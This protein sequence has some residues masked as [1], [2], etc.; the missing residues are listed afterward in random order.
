MADGARKRWTLAFFLSCLATVAL[1][2]DELETLDADFLS[3]L[4]EFEGEHDDWT[5]VEPPRKLQ[6]A[7]ETAAKPPAQPSPTPKAPPPSPQPESKP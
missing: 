3:Y 7:S 1:S 4:A 5:I 6:P 2:A